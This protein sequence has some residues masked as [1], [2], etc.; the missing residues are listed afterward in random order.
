MDVLIFIC[1]ALKMI[2][3]AFMIISVPMFAMEF[4]DDSGNGAYVYKAKNYFFVGMS[5]FFIGQTL[6]IYIDSIQNNNDYN[7]T[8]IIFLFIFSLIPATIRFAVIIKQKIYEKKSFLW[9]KEVQERYSDKEEINIMLQHLDGISYV[10]EE[11]ES[12]S[13][14]YI[15]FEKDFIHGYII[16]NSDDNEKILVVLSDEN[17]EHFDY[18]ITKI[19]ENENRIDFCYWMKDGFYYS[20]IKKINIK[21]KD[22]EYINF[23]PYVISYV[24]YNAKKNETYYTSNYIGQ[25]EREYLINSIA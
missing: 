7:I 19:N 14:K 9:K 13:R 4:R 23:S 1:D 25:A 8:Q 18:E 17:K 22:A 15:S 16:T 12:E 24:K 20:P 3:I 6:N 2:G 21:I 5:L 11:N 10:I